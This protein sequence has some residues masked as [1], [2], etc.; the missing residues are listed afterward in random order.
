MKEILLKILEKPEYILALC[1]LIISI[2]SLGLAFY[3]SYQNR[4]HNR[5]GVRPYAYILPKDYEDNIAVIIQNK[6]TGPLITKTISFCKNGVDNKKYLIDFM[7]SLYDGY[8]W[9]T[10][11]KAQKIIL[12]PSEEKVLIEFS[13]KLTDNDFKKQRD[14][15]R[16]AL[17]EIEMNIE[18][19][20]IYNEKKPFKLNYKLD[21]Y[22]REK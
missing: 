4:L 17:S 15:I 10:F 8:Y 19:T 16:K 13:G 1:A 22:K 9:S 14:L 3:S 5:L 18:Y 21:W 20:S 12:R 2:I 7:P 11:S 6:G